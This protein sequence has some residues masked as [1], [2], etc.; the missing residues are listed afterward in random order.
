[1]KE[2]FNLFLTAPE[3]RVVALGKQNKNFPLPCRKLQIQITDSWNGALMYSKHATEGLRFLKNFL[4]HGTL[5]LGHPR[6][7]IACVLLHCPIR[8]SSGQNLT[9]GHRALSLLALVRLL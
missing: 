4:N 7:T 8:Y 6:A 2:A 1:M 3:L 9:C 5:Q